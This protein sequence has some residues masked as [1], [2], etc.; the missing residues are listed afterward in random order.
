[1]DIRVYLQKTTGV[2]HKE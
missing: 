1:M 2:N